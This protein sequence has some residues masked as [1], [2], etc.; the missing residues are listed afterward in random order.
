[1]LFFSKE[2]TLITGNIKRPKKALESELESSPTTWNH[3][4][5]VLVVSL[6]KL[7]N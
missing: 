3:G 7:P 2:R 5:V 1:M 6:W 4:L